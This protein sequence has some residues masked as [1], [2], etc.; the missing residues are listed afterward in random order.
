MPD[1]TLVN[2]AHVMAAMAE[3]DQLGSREFLRRHG[4][5]QARAYALWHSGREYPSKAILGVAYLR[6]T[7]RP[8]TAA[9][10]SGDE[11][12]EAK[13]LSALG[14]DVV[15][16]EQPFRPTRSSR[17]KPKPAPRKAEPVLQVCPRCFT[18][19]PATGV[20]DYCD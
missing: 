5:G 7:G 1:W 20:C 13:V 10:F 8:A 19:L 14:F 6:A 11:Q 4:F 9:E 2:R 3:H 12:E 17:P 18:A 15:A 16:E